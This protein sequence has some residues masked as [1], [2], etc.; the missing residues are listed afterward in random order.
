MILDYLATPEIWASFLTLSL[1]EIVL[2][3]DNLVFLSVITEKL[4]PDQA[5]KARRIGLA[6]ALIMRIALL[7]MLSW[8]IGL[9]APILTIYD[10]IFSW[11]D[12]ILGA[13][14]LF[15]LYKGTREIHAVVE[16]EEEHGS[17]KMALGMAAAII[18]IMILDAVFSLDS[19]IT[20][21]G[22]TTELPVMVAAVVFAILVMLFAAEP[23]AAFISRHPTTKMLALSFLLLVGVALVADGMHFHIPRGYL[24]FA[25]AFSLL[26]EGLNLAAMRR[27]TRL[28]AE[29]KK[30]S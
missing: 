17:E 27:R 9:T 20:A 11:R 23:V 14:G 26:V 3:I 2:G 15:L 29:G 28:R 18:Q 12:L 4:P 19:V 13:G 8:I 7:L 10:F 6:G 30:Q 21:V 25:I 22:M 16:G 5:K 1:L 24:Y